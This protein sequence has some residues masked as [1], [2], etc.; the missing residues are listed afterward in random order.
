MSGW[1]PIVV[2]LASA[3]GQTVLPGPQ[4]RAVPMVQAPAPLAAFTLTVTP[5][6]ITFSATDPDSPTVAG[7]APASATWRTSGVFGTW[8]LSVQSTAATFQGCATVPVSAVRVSCT[9]AS[10]S[11]LFGSGSCSSAFA[12]STSSQ[13]IASGGEG[14]STGNYAVTLT[15]TLTDSWKYIA[16][17]SPSCSLNL[18]YTANVP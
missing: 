2:L 4:S 14:L 10:N 1:L 17:L 13:V 11:A 15:F 18:S 7:S 8:T 16:Q 12:L 6:V 9:S 3:S 5:S